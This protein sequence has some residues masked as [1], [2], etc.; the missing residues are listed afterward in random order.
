MF[1][2]EKEIAGVYLGDKEMSGIFLGD[3]ENWTSSKPW[4]A[5]SCDGKT[6]TANS[7]STIPTGVGASPY[8]LPAQYMWSVG[9]T[10]ALS[11]ESKN[12]DGTPF[13]PTNKCKYMDVIVRADAGHQTICEITGKKKD[14][15]EVVILSQKIPLFNNN[16]QNV[17]NGVTLDN[18][19][20]C[21]ITNVDVNGYDS[22]KVK[23]YCNVTG[24][25]HSV[26]LG[27]MVFHN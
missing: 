27:R 14:G 11:I 10:G 26:G 2:G 19:Y 12:V 17:I 22:V 6:L 3:K 13:I 21:N 7:P 16:T 24:A 25:G 20:P 23:N 1:L 18:K 8:E 9:G 15:T 5:I 4:E